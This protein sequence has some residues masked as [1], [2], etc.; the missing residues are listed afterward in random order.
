MKDLGEAVGV[1]LVFAF[2]LFAVSKCS[3]NEKRR[4]FLTCSKE[5]LLNCEV[6]LK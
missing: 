1:L 4:D 3:D 2:L 5:K 6:I